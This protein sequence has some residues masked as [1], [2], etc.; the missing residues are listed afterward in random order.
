MAVGETGLSGAIPSRFPIFPLPGAILLP[1]GNLP[2]NIFEPRY[3][4]MTRDAMRTDQV[5]GMMQPCGD[6]AGERPE[7]YQ[8][9]CVG[10]IASFSET[11]DGRYLISLTGLCRYDVLEE[12][13]GD[14]ALSPGGRELRALEPRS[15][16]AGAVGQPAADAVRGAARLFRGQRHQRRLGADRG[17]AA[18]R[19]DHLAR[20]DLS[21]SSRARSR[22][23][24]RRQASTSVAGC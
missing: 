12:L 16:G 24:S 4:H 22:R 9:G 23:C 6:A 15:R 7:I 3:L 20:D 21:R 18:R 5:I 2:L 17:R 14:D 13:A 10:R 8:V 11:E 1:G 19:P